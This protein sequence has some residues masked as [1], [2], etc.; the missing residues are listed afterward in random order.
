LF[1]YLTT[2]NVFDAFK[3]SKTYMRPLFEPFEE[4]ERIARN[5]PHPS[6]DKAYPKTTDG[7]TASIVQKTPRR[8]I[9]Q[10]PTGVVEN[11]SEDWLS[12]VAGFIYTSKI[13]PLANAQYDLI[14]KCWSA[15][16]KSLTFGSQ[17]AYIPWLQKG[18]TFSVDITLPY[19]KDVFLE[20]GKLS[21]KD[22]NY[23][24]M[25]SWYQPADIKAIINRESKLKDS[26]SGW[27]IE[28]LK[29]IQDKI[30][31]KDDLSVTPNEKN[32][33]N[34][35]GGVEI[36]HAFQSG[37]GADFYSFHLSSEKIVRTKKNKDP[38]GKMP[39]HYLYSDI[40]MSNPLGRGFVELV[41]PMQNLMDAEVQMY[42]YNRALMLNPPIIKKGN[43]SKSQAKLVPNT[44]WDLGS[45]PLSSAEALEIDT[46]AIAN[47][48][49][50]YG[51]MK[52]QLLNLLSS[53]DT[54]ISADVG[55]PG[56]S[57]T[58]AGVKNRESV[59]NVD[60]NYI[61]KQFEGWF[62]D[63][64]ETM[65]NLY[66]AERSGK[67]VIQLDDE[68][69]LKL[70]IAKDFDP[71]AIT[72][73][74][75]IIIDFD[76]ETPK[77]KFHVDAS[78]SNMKDNADQVDKA[79][80]LLELTMK[81]PQLDIKQGGPVDSKELTDRIVVNSGI[82][83]PEK[84]VPKNDQNSGQEQTPP[85]ITPEQV[86]QMI[87]DAMQQAKGQPK[88][89][90]ES[91]RWTPQDLTPVERAQA[92]EQGG[93]K[94]DDTATT[95]NEDKQTAELIGKQHDI[96]NSIAPPT[97]GQTDPSQPQTDSAQ[98]QDSPPSEDVAYMAELQKHGLSP[99]QS[100]QALVMLHNGYPV[101]QV[102]NMLG[103]Q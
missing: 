6:I 68:T 2:E 38:R 88:S 3:K 34:R 39:I 101:D 55:N 82:E 48:P 13:L 22:S 41:A 66:F 47:F 86:Q 103:A 7:T 62:E 25:R 90:S 35:N 27:D 40:D 29:E 76:T 85:P 89:I 37:I 49:A 52:S 43:W 16:S 57:K 5:R 94:A 28:A 79:T 44:I 23:I 54:S 99:E 91:I 64:S 77:L 80:N 87:Q 81:Y 9:Q 102:L 74:N 60:D 98:P 26:E 45:D 1:S 96:L 59:L 95:P 51:L 17:P 18:D 24:F 10:L 73:D 70:R 33:N 32:R 4:F 83:D 69:A 42:Q 56:F 93:I 21:D 78:T 53:P 92:L 75:K 36:I 97:Q 72:E 100:S 30:S 61:R 65:I 8:I 14:Q 63:V 20:P 11:D 46:S 50:N 67:E 15:C 12:I 84:V 19:I 31:Q 71:E 58:D